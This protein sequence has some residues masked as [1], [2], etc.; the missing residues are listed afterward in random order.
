MVIRLIEDMRP[1]T[2]GGVAY[3]FP[4]DVAALREL[5]SSLDVLSDNNVTTLAN[6]CP[7]RVPQDTGHVLLDTG[8]FERTGD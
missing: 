8:C 1:R 7:I 2:F 4:P 6:G 3:L 5:L